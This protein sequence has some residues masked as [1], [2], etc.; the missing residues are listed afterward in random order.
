MDM[1]NIYM[2]MVQYTME[3]GQTIPNMEL[4]MKYGMILLNIMA[5]IIMGKKMELVL[6]IGRINQCIRGSGKIIL[7]KDLVFIILLMGGLIQE[8]G[9]KINN[10]VMENLHGLKEK[11]IMDFI[12]VIKKM[13]LEYI[14]G[15]E[16]NFFQHFG[17]MENKMAPVNLLKG[18]QLNMENGKMVK[19]KKYLV[20]KINFLI[21]QS[22]MKKNIQ[23][24]FS[25]ILID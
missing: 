24:I 23:Y 16:K 18:N 4:V 12:N 19:K 2:K 13:D 11:N 17:K 21:V 20:M 25:G 14:I 1:V 3:I 22:Q 15:L 7:W 9:K 10:M 5:I 8:N 6:I